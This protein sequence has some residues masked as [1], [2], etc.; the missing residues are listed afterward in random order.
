MGRGQRLI[1]GDGR[2]GNPEYSLAGRTANPASKLVGP[3]SDLFAAIQAWHFDE[4]VFHCQ[5]ALPRQLNPCNLLAGAAPAKPT[6]A[7]GW[8]L[9]TKPSGMSLIVDSPIVYKRSCSRHEEK[10]GPARHSQALGFAVKARREALEMTQEDLAEAARIHRTYLSDV[11][12]GTRNL[13]LVN[14]ERLALALRMTL[15]E[16]FARVEAGP[17]R[18]RPSSARPG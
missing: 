16:L 9:G 17:E 1:D 10:G 8:I 5:H 2:G 3:D 12:R 7:L 13:S 4:F 15:A 11:E 14:I 6:P 18:P